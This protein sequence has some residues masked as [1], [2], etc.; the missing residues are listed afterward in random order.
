M[1]SQAWTLLAIFLTIL[2]VGGYL[3]AR[4]F[5][6]V[7]ENPTIG[8]LEGVVYRAIGVRIDSR[9]S[10][11]KYA[12]ALLLFS[13]FGVVLL[14]AIQRLQ[15]LLPWNPDH[16]PAVPWDLAINTA[17]SFVTNTN[18]QA[19]SGEATLSHFT[20]MAGLGTQNFVSASAGMAVAVALARGFRN[21][22]ASD[23]G[24]FWR[25]LTR[26]ALYILLPLSI[27]LAIA[28]MGEEVI[29]NFNPST[30]ATT[31]SGLE[32]K[33]PGGP[34]ASQIAI[35]QL[36]TNG[37]GFFGVNSAHPFEN[38]TPLSNFLQTIA[39]LL[40]PAAFPFLFG[41]LIKQRRQG[42]LLF[43]VMG[44]LFLASLGVAVWSESKIN[45]L[46]QL[47]FLE[48][49]EFRF[50]PFESVL[51]GSSTTAASNG[52]VNSMH[53]SFSPIAGMMFLFNIMLGEIIFGGVGSGLYGM[54]L[55]AVLTVFLCGL[56]VGRSPEYLG[57]KIESREIVLAGIGALLPGLC[58]L[59]G[60]AWMTI[61]PQTLQGVTNAGPHGLTQLL[62]TAS[63]AAGNNGSAF[64]GFGANT[65]FS[66]LLLAALMWLGRFGVIVSVLLL[67]QAVGEK[68]KVAVSTGTL[69]T[70]TAIFAALLIGV[71]LLIGGLT[72]F[73][74]IM[75][76]PLLEHG[77][78]IRRITF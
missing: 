69:P 23:I 17:V 71:I 68:K 49:K 48:G 3:L 62:Y 29:Q 14:V 39:L 73:P 4:Y 56:M 57:K 76:G 46:T 53:D 22:E 25:D 67:A 34:A 59:I 26:G 1:D 77:A 7:Y 38:P 47:P 36:G 28:L 51:W 37:G 10:A 42:W 78:L 63:S 21:H 66:N 31:F 70:D 16:L 41:R 5:E 19:Y 54:V 20:Q 9:M 65:T 32:Q 27:L 58:I 44:V 43:G 74:T 30:S 75:L 6:W 8:W 45:P 12:G 33:I 72:F 13:I 61:H 60:A 11:S 18:W 2:T 35:K 15:G 64:A 24:N 40:I 52:S 50:T 55:F